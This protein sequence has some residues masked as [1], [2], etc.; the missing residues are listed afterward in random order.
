MLENVRQLKIRKRTS[1]SLDDLMFKHFQKKSISDPGFSSLCTCRGGAVLEQH[2]L[3]DEFEWT[4][5]VEF[6]HSILI[7]HTATDLCYRT[8]VGQISEELTDNLLHSKQ[9]ADYMLYLLVMCPLM[10]PKGIGIIRFRD[11]CAEAIEYFT[12]KGLKSAK[13]V[14]DMLLL[15]VSAHVPL[16][17]RVWGGRSKSVLLEACRLAQSL[18]QLGNEERWEMVSNVWVEMLGYAAN[19]CRG[20]YHAQQLQEGGEL[21][22]HVWLLMSHLGITQQFEL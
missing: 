17:A 16:V 14:C 3:L 5:N 21:L 11:T 15:Q 9:L 19:N 7:W 6:D 10:M 1:N 12:D 2:H 20:Y 13:D 22:T 4:T 8:D 18:Q